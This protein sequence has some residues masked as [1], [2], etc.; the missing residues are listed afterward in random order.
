[1]FTGI[2][3]ALFQPKTKLSLKDWVPEIHKYNT[4]HDTIQDESYNGNVIYL[5]A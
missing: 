4:I 1:M 5:P 2:I 3:H